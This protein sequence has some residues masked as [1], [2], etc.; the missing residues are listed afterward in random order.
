MSKLE[1]VVYHKIA[2]EFKQAVKENRI[3]DDER[4]E[5]LVALHRLIYRG[6]LDE[7]LD[8]NPVLDKVYKQ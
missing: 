6:S 2:M 4:S 7:R 5:I 3:T 1:P 8:L